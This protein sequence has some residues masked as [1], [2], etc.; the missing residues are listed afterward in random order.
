VSAKLSVGRDGLLDSCWCGLGL[1]ACV[2]NDQVV[3]VNDLV[4]DNEAD[5]NFI[6][7]LAD[8]PGMEG[9][10]DKL[11][12]VSYQSSKRM[13]A[14]GTQGGRVIVW[15]HNGSRP[16]TGD[17]AQPE[18]AWTPLPPVDIGTQPEALTWA[19]ADSVLAVCSSAGLHV[20]PETIPRRVMR[21]AWGTVR[22]SERTGTPS[23]PFG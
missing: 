9:R 21:D 3:R 14:A 1:L 12:T 11:T 13:L 2:S 7:T 8:V 6:L 15:K 18:R 23:L 10:Q 20:C 5:D 22:L 17:A 16:L 4:E 19:G